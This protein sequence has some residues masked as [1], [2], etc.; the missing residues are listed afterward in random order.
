[1][2][3]EIVGRE[4]L[5][6]QLHAFIGEGREGG[7]AGLVLEG[8]AGIGK[9]TLWLAAIDDARAQGLRVLSSRPAEAERE[10]AHVGL[11]DL[12][13][14]V[15]DDVLPLL[16]TPRR[17]A[18]EVALLRDDSSDDPVD[19]RALAVAV[20]GV[21]QVLSR[22]EPVLLAV[23]DVQWLDPTS[24]SA[25]A[26]ALRRLDG[27]DVRLL[28][29]RRIVEGRQAIGL[30]Q[31][32]APERVERLHVGPL[33]VGG[34]HRFLRDRLGRPL[35]R[36]TLLR[37]HGRSEGN[38]FFALELSRG[39]DVDLD[40]L[41]QLTV[42][43]TLEELVRARFS[44]L[45]A[46]TR[47]ALAFVSAVGA[48]PV[49][50]LEH[51]GVTAH[52]LDPAFAAR[53]LERE[54]GLIRFT[55]PL[56]ASVLYQDL[57]EER[58]QIH[59]RIAGLVDDPLL[60]ARHLA[61]SVDAPDAE[62]AVVLDT[63]VALATDRGAAAVAAELAEHA[64]RLTFPQPP[65]EHR[66]RGLAAARAH[67]AAGEWTRART[68][69]RGLL[70]DAELTSGRVE[71]LLL[72]AELE[73]ADRALPLLEEALQEAGGRPALQAA[74]HCRL[75]WAARWRTGREHARAALALAEQLD[76]DVLR[77]RARAVSAI[78]G[79]FEGDAEA[80]RDLLEHVRDF[81]PAVG[82]EQLV[83]E[84]LQAVV[85]TFAPAS[86]R[87][88]V[89]AFFEHE[90]AEW[91]DRDERPV[92]RALWG[93]AW[94]EL[95]AGRWR[96]AATHAAAALD[97][98]NQYGLEVPQDH[99]PISVIAVHRGEIEVARQH[100][101][102]ALTLA[103]EQF[104]ESWHPP[105]HLAVL[106]LVALWDG[107]ESAAASGFSKADAKRTVVDARSRRAS[108]RARADRRCRRTHRPLGR[109]WDAGT[110]RMG[111]RACDALPRARGCG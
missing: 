20:H 73:S 53:V 111:A 91:R 23:D 55:H 70:A 96:A 29:A 31:A 41:R 39:L 68:I 40:P 102:R 13:D 42:P 71:A 22:R 52:A 67:Q 76:D 100:S 47:D 10:L 94:V 88:Q 63:A 8:E 6:E 44:G 89:R 32:L 45:P 61:L 28:L 92:A 19:D 62:V 103:E 75:A 24:S 83:Q 87:D 30:E 74:V 93:L 64:L 110:T 33:S 54:A 72:L 26:F 90:L 7:L 109:G 18:L 49:S 82:G 11:G 3:V 98:S 4:E 85:N 105:Q 59:A 78:L 95:W 48:T 34:L 57:G 108:S 43:D 21:L 77:A 69:A 101:A 38:P 65:E 56:L 25:L 17:R 81:A 36:Q 2:R 9:S 50:L 66:R 80:S 5:L 51:A 106:A 104:L 15:L 86:L 1:M 107:D 60:S 79:W 46:S 84:A 14:G 12:F 16:S 35:P 27:N 99:L 58:R 37:V 97:L